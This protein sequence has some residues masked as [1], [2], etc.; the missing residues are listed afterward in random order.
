[1][2][3][4]RVFFVL[5]CLWQNFLK[6]CENFT[7][8][9]H[10]LFSHGVFLFFSLV[11]ISA[12]VFYAFLMF[13]DVFCCPLML[14]V[15]LL[16]CIDMVILLSAA[17]YL[18][19]GRLCMRHWRSPFGKKQESSWDVGPPSSLVISWMRCAQYSDCNVHRV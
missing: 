7:L 6:R 14:C 16:D 5:S 10:F 2:A 11:C 4:V 12:C 15:L 13:R 1:M 19:L 3:C 17:F 18:C 8:D 9:L